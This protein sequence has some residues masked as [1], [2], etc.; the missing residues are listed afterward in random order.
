LLHCVPP[1]QKPEFFLILGPSIHP[2]V[3]FLDSAHCI[4]LSFMHFHLS[5]L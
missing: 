1:I 2:S 5:F 4:A 3:P